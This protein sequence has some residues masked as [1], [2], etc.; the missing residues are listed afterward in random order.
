MPEIKNTFLKGKMNKDLDDRLVP[1]GEYRDALNI[2]V[3]QSDGSDVGAIENIKNHSPINVSFN[4]PESGVKVIGSIFDDKTDTVYWFATNN[5]NHYIYKW[6]DGDATPTLLVSGSFLNFNTSNLITGIN[7]LEGFLY[8]TD[9]RNQ[10][11]RIKI[12]KAESDNTFYDS[13]LLISVAKYAPYKA[14]K[15]TGM[16]NESNIYSTEIKEKFVRFAYRYKFEDNEYSVISPFSDIAFVPKDDVINPSD[17]IHAFATSEIAGMVNGINQVVMDIDVPADIQIKEIEILSKESN[18]PAIRIV[19]TKPYSDV[20][21]GELEYTYKSTKPKGTLPE[22]QLIRV[23]DNVPIKALAQE[24]ISNRLVYGN[25]SLG[26]KYE[27]P[28]PDYRVFYG[29]KTDSSILENHSIKQRRTYQVGIVFSDIHGRST[30]VYTSPYSTIYVPAKSSSFDNS[31][32]SGD[33]LKIMF[34]DQISNAYDASTNP[35]GW[36]SYKIVVKQLEQEYYNV[37]TSGIINRG[38]NEGKAYIELIKDNVN[39]VPRDTTNSDIQN[40][41]IA[42]SK[43][44]LYP[45]VV[46]EYGPDT[47]SDRHISTNSD[48]DLITVTGIAKAVDFNL[49]QPDGSTNL[50]ASMYNED[51]SPLL[52]RLGSNLGLQNTIFSNQL[53][54]LET[55]PFI[56]TLD[57]YYETAFAGKVTDLNTSIANGLDLVAWSVDNTNTSNLSVSFSEATTLQTKVAT[58]Y[59]FSSTSP[60]EV[61]SEGVSFAIDGSSNDF[62]IEFVDNEYILKTKNTF[63]SGTNPSNLTVIASFPGDTPISNDISFTIN[64]AAPTIEV[65]SSTYTVATNQANNASLVTFTYSNGSAGGS[66]TGVTVIASDSTNAFG[67]TDNGDGTGYIKVTDNSNLTA[68]TTV[69]VTL[70]ASD[71]TDTATASCVFTVVAAGGVYE[72]TEFALAPATAFSS[73]ADACNNYNSGQWSDITIYSTSDD[74]MNVST[75]VAIYKNSGL[76]AYGASGWYKD[77]ANGIVGRWYGSVSQGYWFIAPF[78]CT[79]I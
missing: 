54:V 42:D 23:Y 10:P 69:T 45:K 48:E 62:E 63:V 58:L 31:S 5:T 64:N 29:E 21:S 3:S 14:P 38:L 66:S 25:I 9:N 53:A 35:L 50:I 24:I 19:D 17:E 39:K 36:Y 70:T 26:T 34:L 67:I 65:A 15:I 55:E 4:Y 8:W 72:L 47:L 22:D 2:T 37:Y 76:T 74:P 30:P 43:I 75:P 13:E 41:S 40:D 79:N 28:K 33:E 27:M 46:N 11:R 49:V 1:E 18:S 20:V 16:S 6:T 12:S 68:S 61:L 60:I 77:K 44:R 52:A 57:I 71:G 32:F 73:T 59:A 51:E 7:I 56:S 78:T